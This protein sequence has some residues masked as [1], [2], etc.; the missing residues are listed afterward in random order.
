[1]IT[2]C[3]WTAKYREWIPLVLCLCATGSFF[4][5]WIT[6]PMQQRP[7][8]SGV[9]FPPHNAHPHYI[10]DQDVAWS[11]WDLLR[12]RHDDY[13]QQIERDLFPEEHTLVWPATQT[14][15]PLSMFPAMLLFLYAWYTPIRFLRPQLSRISIGGLM[16]AII[17]IMSIKFTAS[18]DFNTEP[19]SHTTFFYRSTLAY[20]TY[21]TSMLLLALLVLQFEN[22]DG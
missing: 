3:A 22:L 5:P 4:L 1:M 14:L 19:Y 18:L 11:A 8:R 12:E 15:A 2:R 17:A 21:S 10:S 7:S 13:I 20:G 6:P 16:L 9:A